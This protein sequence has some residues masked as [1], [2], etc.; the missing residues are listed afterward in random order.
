MKNL[1]LLTLAVLINCAASNVIKNNENIN[2]DIPGIY[3]GNTCFD[4]VPTGSI[5]SDITININ[6]RFTLKCYYYK[7]ANDTVYIVKEE[8]F[9]KI[10]KQNIIF[11]VS[12]FFSNDHPPEL[13]LVNNQIIAAKQIPLEVNLKYKSRLYIKD[14]R[15][16][17]KLFKEEFIKSIINY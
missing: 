9:W 7:N 8:G 13:E 3:N 11:N 16:R 10:D 6:G 5:Y 1:F 14:N 15:L 12:T 2:N 17:L 4:C